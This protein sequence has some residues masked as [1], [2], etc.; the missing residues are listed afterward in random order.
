V[1]HE[2]GAQTYL[3]TLC[4]QQLAAQHRTE[5]LSDE[6]IHRLERNWSAAVNAFTGGH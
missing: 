2:G 5:R 1:G 4:D 6:E 3:C